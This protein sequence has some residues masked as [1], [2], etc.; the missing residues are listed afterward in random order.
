MV[1]VLFALEDRNL[2]D[3]KTNECYGAYNEPLM[4]FHIISY[5]FFDIITPV[6]SEI[7]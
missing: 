7:V 2:S 5:P 4:T 6:F 1:K 3:A